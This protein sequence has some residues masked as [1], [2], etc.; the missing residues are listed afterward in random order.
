VTF[1]PRLGAGGAKAAARDGLQAIRVKV[2]V[3]GDAARRW[4]DR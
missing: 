4:T 1:K 3:E 2:L